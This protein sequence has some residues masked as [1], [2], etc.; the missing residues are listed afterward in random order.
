MFFVY[1]SQAHACPKLL[2]EHHSP[3]KKLITVTILIALEH[4]S[5]SC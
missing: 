2:L 4:I 5:G 1:T 3:S